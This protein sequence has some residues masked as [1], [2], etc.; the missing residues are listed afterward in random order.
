[1]GSPPSFCL[2]LHQVAFGR[3]RARVT[4]AVRGP[5]SESCGG[6]GRAGLDLDVL[7]HAALAL[8]P[9]PLLLGLRL[10]R[11]TTSA[12]VATAKPTAMARTVANIAASCRG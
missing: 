12:A 9:L 7:G 1:M 3:L 6:Q 2:D 10:G 11:P 4:P 8:A 5:R